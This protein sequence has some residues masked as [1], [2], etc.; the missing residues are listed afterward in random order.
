MESDNANKILLDPRR[1]Q[2][3]EPEVARWIWR[4]I[5]ET[6]TLDRPPME[7]GRSAVGTESN[8]AWRLVDGGPFLIEI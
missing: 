6:R 8:P 7:L 4:T 2:G 5:N 1:G 3:C